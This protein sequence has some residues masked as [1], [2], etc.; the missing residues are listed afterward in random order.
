VRAIDHNT[1]GQ[2]T[3]LVMKPDHT[4][5][6]RN[7]DAAR[8]AGDN[9]VVRSGLNDGEQVV[10]A[11]G[12]KLQPGAHVKPVDEQTHPAQSPRVAAR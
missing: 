12:Q 10:V 1:Q 2:A 8:I 9:W 11:G 7:V 4:V 3:A 6:R 5:E